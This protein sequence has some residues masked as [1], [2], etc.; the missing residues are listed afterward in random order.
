MYRRT[1]GSSMHL[2]I[3][4][5]VDTQ[6]SHSRSCSYLRMLSR[7]HSKVSA[8][9]GL[10]RQGGGTQGQACIL[11]CCHGATA[12]SAFHLAFEGEVNALRVQLAFPAVLALQLGP[13]AP[14]YQLLHRLEVCPKL[15]HELQHTAVAFGAENF[16]LL[17]SMRTA[18]HVPS[19]QVGTNS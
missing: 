17:N 18:I 6:G 10:G 14:R 3:K 2:A 11:R 1:H 16:L 12:R 5:K 13:G 7:S 15:A 19:T 8:S 9:P 4:D